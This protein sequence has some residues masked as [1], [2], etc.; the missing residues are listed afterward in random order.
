MRVP[1]PLHWYIGDAFPYSLLFG[2]AR[3]P[4][5]QYII[6]LVRQFFIHIAGIT[7]PNQI[8][9][10]N[11]KVRMHWLHHLPGPQDSV[12]SGESL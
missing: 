3:K 12:F 8:A 2:P 11:E 7:S 9:L 6:H 10:E 5:I 4:S 1:Q